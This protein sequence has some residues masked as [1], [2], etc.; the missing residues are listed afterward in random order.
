[1]P[2]F[3]ICRGC[4]LM[5]VYFGGT[6][7]QDI[8]TQ[9]PQ[10]LEHRNADLYDQVSHSVTLVEGELLE[11][12]YGKSPNARVNTVHHQAIKELGKDLK[13]MAHSPQDGI[14]EAIRWAPDGD[15]NPPFVVG[16]QW[17]PEF[18]VGSKTEGMLNSNLLYDAFLGAVTES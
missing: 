2:V 10:A 11:R 14:I 12:I 6:L 9:Q 7:Y 4:Q 8:A 5:N 17:H 1:M 18:A 13:V 15:E 16:V 3:A